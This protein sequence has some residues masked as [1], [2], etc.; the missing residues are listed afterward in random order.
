MWQILWVCRPRQFI[1]SQWSE[2]QGPCAPFFQVSAPGEQDGGAGGLRLPPS[3]RANAF[4]QQR[5]NRKNGFQ[6]NVPPIL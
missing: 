5:V 3:S 4:N 6:G 1:C 2:F